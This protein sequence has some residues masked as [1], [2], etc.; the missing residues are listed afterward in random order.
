MIFRLKKYAELKVDENACITEYKLKEVRAKKR[1]NTAKTRGRPKRVRTER[2]ENAATSQEDGES[3]DE[4][5]ESTRPGVSEEAMENSDDEENLIIDN[6]IPG[7]GVV[8]NW[9]PERRNNAPKREWDDYDDEGIP[10]VAEPII[11]QVTPAPSR[12][13]RPKAEVHTPMVYGGNELEVAV[14]E[15]VAEQEEADQDAENEN[16]WCRQEVEEQGPSTS[17]E[18]LEKVLKRIGEKMD[19]QEENIK[20]IFAEMKNDLEA[21]F[22]EKLSKMKAEL[23]VSIETKMIEVMSQ[24]MK[25]LKNEMKN[26]R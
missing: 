21:F 15:E 10:F 4:E 22:Q 13:E 19:N 12:H 14:E 11:P 24:G 17:T 26:I 20:T 6:V 8:I 16:E 3:V 2:S 7:N 23:E 25:C 18:T 5:A 9:W 1:K